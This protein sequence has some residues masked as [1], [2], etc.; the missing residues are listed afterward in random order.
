[1]RASEVTWEWL[2]SKLEGV[3]G[4]GNTFQAWCPCHDDVSSEH[5]GLSITI[6][7]NG[8]VLCNCRS[9]HC[10]ATLPDVIK[11]LESNNGSSNGHIEVSLTPVKKPKTR[12]MRWW[13]D[14]TGVDESVWAGIGCAGEGEGVKFLFEGR[15]YFK[16]RT[17][18]GHS[19]SERI[20]DKEAPVLWP[21][22]FADLPEE[23]T[24]TEG[25]SDCGTAHAAGLPYAFALTKGAKTKLTTAHFEALARRGVSSVLIAVDCDEE[26]ILARETL[27]KAA[28]DADLNVRVVE[29]ETVIDP[30]S[31]GNDLNWLWRNTDRH[32][33]HE[34][35]AKATRDAR[36]F[37]PRVTLQEVGDLLADDEFFYLPGLISPQDKGI[38]GGP[39]KSYKTWMMLDLCRALVACKPFMGRQAWAPTSPINV[40]LIEE[41]GSRRSWAKRINRLQLT[42]EE[43]ETLLHLAPRRIHIHG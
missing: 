27:E 3:E 40:L 9:P 29:L 38:L 11:V 43:Y 16:L 20:S 37:D 2:E 12:G 10:G 5:K 1:M 23:I 17:Y 30:F 32:T 33:F 18:E 28:V 41:E 19:W 26:G 21:M 39:Q 14:K 36:R 6:L 4:S 15:P 25:E 42:D 24:I 7:D 35:L 34:L 22:P 31:N 8:K 13:T